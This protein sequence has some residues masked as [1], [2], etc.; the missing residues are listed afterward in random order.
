MNNNIQGPT[1]QQLP[2]I[3]NTPLEPN[4][5]TED[6]NGQLVSYFSLPY[7]DNLTYKLANVF[8]QYNNIKIANKQVKALSK[9][10]SRTK[11]P[12]HIMEN[13]NVVY[14]LQCR[15]CDLSYIGQTSRNLKGRITSHKSDCRRGVL[16]CAL[17]E[18]VSNLDHRIDWDGAEILDRADSF[19]KRAFLEM[20][21][22]NSQANTMN[23]RSDTQSLSVIYGYIL[24]LYSGNY[25][26][27]RQVA[28][29]GSQ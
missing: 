11:T 17:L 13:W 27:L 26:S 2:N 6:Q 3:T 28:T 20:V 7:I 14:R 22:I 29:Q 18:H 5:V 10:Y 19:C 25:G 12:L 16:S 24:D 4:R 1:A 9:L 8:R 15:D 21:H 23:K